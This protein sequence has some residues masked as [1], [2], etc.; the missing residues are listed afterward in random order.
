VPIGG[1]G[2]ETVYACNE[3]SGNC[4]DLDADVDNGEIET[5]YFPK[6]GNVDIYW[7]G[8]CYD[9]PCYATDENDNEWYIE[10][11]EYESDY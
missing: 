5:L 9:G 2:T 7:D 3:S 11:E 4:Y 1:Q 8:D 10:R 6:G